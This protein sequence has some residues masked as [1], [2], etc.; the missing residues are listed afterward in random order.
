MDVATLREVG[1]HQVVADQELEFS[2]LVLVQAE[3]PGDAASEDRTLLRVPAAEALAAVVQKDAE[4]Q[5][6][7]LVDVAHGLREQRRQLRALAAAQSFEFP[8]THE[9]VLVHRVDVV[10]VVEH[11]TA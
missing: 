7:R 6:F 2:G 11:E 10:L 3:T 9:R 8:D 5:K 4:N 1:H